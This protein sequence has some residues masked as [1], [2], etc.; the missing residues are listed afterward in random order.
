MF[1]LPC[2]GTVLI[3]LKIELNRDN[4]VDMLATTGISVLLERIRSDIVDVALAECYADGLHE[5]S[6]SEPLRKPLN[7]EHAILAISKLMRSFLHNKAVQQSSCACVW[8]LALHKDSR[9]D[10]ETGD[11]AP[12][13][14]H[15]IDRFRDDRVLLH[16]A[17]GALWNCTWLTDMTAARICEIDGISILLDVAT[18][19]KADPVI[20]VNVLGVLWNMASQEPISRQLVS[21]GCIRVV[22]TLM[23]LH[24]TGTV[25][26]SP[27]SFAIH[28]LTSF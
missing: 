16:R 15:A 20:A 21:A 5:L 3:M 8:N 11:V 19:Y 28:C 23:D 6:K 12:L 13:L 7:N 22:L 26:T 9:A 2:T 25:I 18:S 4:A 14:I 10:V 27:L 1:R 24:P 17:L